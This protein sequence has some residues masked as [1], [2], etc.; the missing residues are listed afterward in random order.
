MIPLSLAQGLALGPGRRSAW[1][2]SAELRE[3]GHN[4]YSARVSAFRTR[5]RPPPDLE[6]AIDAWRAADIVPCR[7]PIRLADRLAPG[8]DR[9]RDAA[10]KVA[11]WT[12][13]T[14]P[15]PDYNSAISGRCP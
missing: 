8:L 13:K 11:T 15:E 1:A 4:K 5:A 3:R 6:Q 2:V 9:N 14:T 12:A 10:I 7:A